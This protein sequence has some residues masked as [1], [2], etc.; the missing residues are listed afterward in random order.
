MGEGSWKAYTHF[1]LL[2]VA[3]NREPQRVL[4]FPL[5]PKRNV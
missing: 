5:S 4:V 3:T 2:I 1:C